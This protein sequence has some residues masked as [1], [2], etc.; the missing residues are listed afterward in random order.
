MRIRIVASAVATLLSLVLCNSRAADLEA[1]PA[2]IR[3]V[4]SVAIISVLRDAIEVQQVGPM[5]FNNNDYLGPVDAWKINAHVRGVLAEALKSRPR[6]EVKDV[7]YDERRLWEAYEKDGVGLGAR[8]RTP[9]GASPK[10]EA[11]RPH[12]TELATAHGIDGFL[13]IVPG[14]RSGPLCAGGCTAYGN[15]GFGVFAR[16]SIPGGDPRLTGSHAYVSADVYFVQPKKA[17]VVAST[18]VSEFRGFATV[19][20]ADFSAIPP[21]GLA[22]LENAIKGLMDAELPKSILRMG[23]LNSPI[24]KTARA[25]GASI[26]ALDVKIE[27]CPDLRKLP[28]EIAANYD[29]AAAANKLKIGS[30]SAVLTIKQ[31]IQAGSRWARVPENNRI[32]AVMTFRGNEYWIQD[33]S[34]WTQE[35]SEAAVNIAEQTLARLK[36]LLYTETK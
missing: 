36:S 13:L 9:L 32:D 29:K 26:P 7:P 35:I 1:D 33:R 16:S 17:D 22:Q 3:D 8:L 11:L 5:V 15:A 31:V 20:M 4:K 28:D 12:L 25:E 23:I 14:G 34:R 24:E 30:E 10:V 2:A 18:L 27:C 6:F 21:G 19:R